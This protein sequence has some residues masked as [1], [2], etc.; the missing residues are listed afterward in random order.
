[1]AQVVKNPD[2]TLTVTLSPLEQKVL[3]RWAAEKAIPP[4]AQFADVVNGFFANKINDYR[5]LDGPTMRDKYDALTPTKQ[6]Q[7]DTLLG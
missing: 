5:G 7:V 3:L 2:N 1:M 4:A 6:A